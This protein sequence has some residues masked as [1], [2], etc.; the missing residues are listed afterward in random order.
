MNGTSLELERRPAH[1]FLSEYDRVLILHSAGQRVAQI[2]LLQDTGGYSRANLYGLAH[3]SLLLVDVEASYL[4][5]T[6]SHEIVRDD[7]RRREGRF[8]GAFDLDATKEWR[9]IPAEEKGESQ[10]D[11]H[12]Q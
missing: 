4:V 5:D 6:E 3:N 10:D 1:L 12:G 11:F 7:V 8:L 2:A 9:F